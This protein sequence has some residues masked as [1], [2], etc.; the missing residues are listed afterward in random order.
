M[1]ARR[2]CA[3]MHNT[4]VCVCVCF[5]LPAASCSLS[6]A[7]LEPLPVER[8]EEGEV[9]GY[10]R[11]QCHSVRSAPLPTCTQCAVSS[12]P[13]LPEYLTS[14]LS[15]STALISTSIPANLMSSTVLPHAG[16]TYCKISS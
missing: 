13:R 15:F 16:D 4:C 2:F 6:S 3:F 7:E 1:S 10:K 9:L 14:I 5:P 11:T 12:V 8:T